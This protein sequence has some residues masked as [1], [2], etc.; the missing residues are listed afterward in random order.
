[1][2]RLNRYIGQTVLFSCLVVL[3]AIIGLDVLFAFVDELKD[4]NKHYTLDVAVRYV[5]LSIP[6]SVYEFIPLASLVGCLIGLGMLASSSELTVMRAAGVSKFRIVLSVSRPVLLLVI[7]AGLIGEFV[8][9]VTGQQATVEKAKA[10]SGGRA[11]GTQYGVW[12]RE[13]NWVMHFNAIERNGLVHGLTLYEFNDQ[14]EL[15]TASFIKEAEYEQGSWKLQRMRTTHFDGDQTRIVV[16][17]EQRWESEL[18]PEFLELLSLAPED[19]SVYNLRGFI[20]YMNSQGINAAPHQLA[21]WSKLMQPLAIFSL[22]LIAV[23]FVFGSLRSVTMGQRVLVGI[24]VG[25][26]F[27]FS[28]DLLGPASTVYGFPPVIAVLTPIGACILAGFW[29]L[30][31]GG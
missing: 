23:S 17:P 2:K 25:L 12:H 19:M 29:M 6:G 10:H 1:M 7:V 4:L 13:G 27:K 11:V 28:Q 30:R 5:L 18:K 15:L 9:P 22:V 8:V 31:R 24:L 14:R 16:M 21:F 3:L 26:V 20:D